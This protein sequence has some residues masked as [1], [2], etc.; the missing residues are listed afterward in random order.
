MN[1]NLYDRK[2]KL[3]QSLVD[4]LKSSF[5]TV[6]SDSN[7]EGFNRNKELQENPVVSYQ[8]LKR[9]KNWFDSYQGNN[10]D[11]P[12][13]LNG[14]DRMKKWC[15]HVLDHW[16]SVD[17]DGKNRRAQ[18]GME[19]QFIDNHEKDG[20]VVNPHDKHEKGINKFDSSITEEVNK[21]KNLISYGNT[22]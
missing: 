18:G 14:G 19:N 17:K 3:P 10:E 22:K 8:Q 15:H 4:H 21:M 6:Q 5:E 9:I 11:T 12:F 1:S 2:A 16:R 13:V 20:M 7:T